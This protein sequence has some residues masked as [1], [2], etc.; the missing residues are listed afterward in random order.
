MM[1]DERSHMSHAANETENS[2]MSKLAP[3]CNDN[4]AETEAK[5]NNLSQ[6]QS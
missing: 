4:V 1:T 2:A 5:N 3:A 6:I